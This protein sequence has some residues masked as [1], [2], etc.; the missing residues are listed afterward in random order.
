MDPGC[1][2]CHVAQGLSN[3]HKAVCTHVVDD[4]PFLIKEF[5]TDYSTVE[6]FNEHRPNLVHKKVPEHDLNAGLAQGRPVIKEVK[7][8]AD[9]DEE[10]KD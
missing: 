10:E 4:V 7:K 2:D 1:K 6:K 8:K 5:T 3:F 9:D